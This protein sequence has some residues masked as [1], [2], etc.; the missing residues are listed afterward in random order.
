MV[1]YEFSYGGDPL[2]ERGTSLGEKQSQLPLHQR[3]PSARRRTQHTTLAPRTSLIP[4][5]DAGL[6]LM[7]ARAELSGTL[8]ANRRLATSLEWVL[9][10]WKAETASRH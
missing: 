8:A 2:K 5:T 9:W 6:L 1:R 3:A 10:R 7:E 4:A